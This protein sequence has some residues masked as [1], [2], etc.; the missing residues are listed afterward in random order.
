M[1]RLPVLHGL[2]RRRILLN[3]RVVPEVLS[4]VL[5]KGFKLKLHRGYGIAGICL[6]R[7]EHIRPSWVPESLGVSSENAAHRIAVLPEV[8]D[9]G[10]H[11]GVYIPRRDT[12]S[13]V[14][15]LTGG[16]LF[17]G[18]H[19]LS[20][21]NVEDHGN[22]LSMEV[23]TNDRKRLLIFSAEETDV[24]PPA[25]CFHSVEEASLFFQTGKVGWSATS[26]CCVLNAVRLETE[27]WRVR[28]LAVKNV[29]SSF[30]SDSHLFPEG[31]VNFD[32]GLIMRDIP[33]QWHGEP[34]LHIS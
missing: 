1:M 5:P 3:F 17:P 11:E 25:S 29:E 19:H 21:F 30:F 14:N 9:V 27:S 32:H 33:H 15:H 34:D 10:H 18:E 20:Q 8:D 23:L 28:P 31:S 2:I 13:I 4:K 12:D 26:N 6:I 24:L 16:R 7:L 22:H